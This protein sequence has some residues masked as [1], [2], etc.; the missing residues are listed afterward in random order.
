MMS[1]VKTA[2]A[3]KAYIL[4]F[5]EGLSY[6]L[7]ANGVDVTVLSPGGTDTPMAENVGF[8]MKKMPFPMM[9][10]EETA[11]IGLKALGKKPS[12]IPGAQNNIMAFMSKHIMIN[13]I[14]MWKVFILLY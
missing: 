6:E 1:L 5:G 8:D 4:A 2:W 13:R 14:I 10:P 3:T 12:V 9:T 7:K 11:A